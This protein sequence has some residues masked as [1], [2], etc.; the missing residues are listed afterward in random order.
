MYYT[1]YVAGQF[2]LK[3]CMSQVMDIAVAV[4][5]LGAIQRKWVIH[6]RGTNQYYNVTA[7]GE[8][9]S[10]NLSNIWKSLGSNKSFASIQHKSFISS[11]CACCRYLIGALH[12]KRED[13]KPRH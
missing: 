4:E 7:A 9:C 11:K 10:E 3:C 6:A 2:E 5:T 12:C 13:L 1:T 8:M